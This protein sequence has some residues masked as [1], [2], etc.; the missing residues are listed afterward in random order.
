M[1]SWSRLAEPPLR[2]PAT[3]QS[4]EYVSGLCISR[5][6][7]STRNKSWLR[8]GRRRGCRTQGEGKAGLPP[9]EPRGIH[10]DRDSEVRWGGI[11]VSVAG[12]WVVSFPRGDSTAICVHSPCSSP[13]VPAAL[14]A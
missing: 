1:S 6:F 4:L 8:L 14:V 9:S 12:P 7:A 10:P 11:T 5:K 2:D 3:L 13:R